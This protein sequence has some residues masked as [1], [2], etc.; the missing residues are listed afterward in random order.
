MR[1]AVYGGSFDPPHVAHGMVA[2]WLLWTGV[3]DEVWLVPSFEHPFAKDMG[4]WTARVAMCQALAE[5]RPGVTLV[6]SALSTATAVRQALGPGTGTGSVQFAVTD[7]VERFTRVG[8]RFLG[9]APS[10]VRWIDLPAATEPFDV[11]AGRDT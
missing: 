3:V 11:L 5:V 8:E 4:P 6:D 9:R 2:S 1:V 10:P 7:H